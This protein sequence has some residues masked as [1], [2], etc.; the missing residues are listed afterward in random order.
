MADLQAAG[1]VYEEGGAV[2]LRSTDHGDDKDRVLFKSDGE[3]TY[4]MP[5]VAYHRDKFGRADRLVNVFGAD[6]HG[7]VARMHAAMA[8]LGHNPAVR[9]VTSV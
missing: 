7:Y 2:W 9:R 5:D 1:A 8:L 4:L 3:P 6:H